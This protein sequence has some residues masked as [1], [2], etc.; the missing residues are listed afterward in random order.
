MGRIGV[1]CGVGIAPGALIE[2][3]A[4]LGAGGFA[5]GFDFVLRGKAL[6]GRAARQHFMR[7]FGMA[8]GAGELADRLAVPIK[9]KPRQPGQNRLGRFGG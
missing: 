8:G 2:R 3:A 7:H 6:V 5:K 4:P 9:A 1:R